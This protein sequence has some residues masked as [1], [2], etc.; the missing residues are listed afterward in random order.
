M[1]PK[2]K[3]AKNPASSAVTTDPAGDEPAPMSDVERM[4]YP[5]LVERKGYIDERLEIISVP[6]VAKKRSK[7]V[8]S[9]GKRSPKS[10]SPSNS[11]MDTA[12]AVGDDGEIPYSPKADTHWDFVMKGKRRLETSCVRINPSCADI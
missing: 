7:P 3:V 1:P 2:L 8:G 5:D 10:S 11:P 4:T 12:A 6:D 9:N